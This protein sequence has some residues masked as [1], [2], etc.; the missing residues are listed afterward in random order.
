MS[1]ANNP[2]RE[3]RSLV[4]SRKQQF[5]AFTGMVL[6]LTGLVAT[7]LLGQ[8]NIITIALCLLGIAIGSIMF[9]PR[10]TRNLSVYANM[11]LYALFF[12]AAAIVFFM[13]LQKH[14]LTFDATESRN[15]SLSTVTSNFLERLDQPIRATVFLANKQDRMS[16]SLLLGEYSRYSPNFDYR[17]VDPFRETGLAQRYSA[18]VLP[19][20]VYLERLTTGTEKAERVVKVAKLDEEQLTNGIV[21]LLRGRDITLYFTTGHGEP[22]LEEDKVAA[23]VS[24]QST[25]PNNLQSLTSQLQRAYVRPV[26]I[27]LSRRDSIPVDASAIIVVRP[28]VDF[29]P[30]ETRL[31]RSYLDQGGRVM[32]LLNPDIPQLGTEIRTALIN[33][34]SLIREFGVELPPEVIVMPLAQQSGQSIYMTPVVAKEHRITQD[35]VTREVISV[36]DQSRPVIPGTPPENTFAESFL[37]SGDQAWAFPIEELQKALISRTDPQITA[38]VDDLKPISIGVAATRMAPG[39][40]EEGAAKIM[41]VGNG[42]FVTTRFLA[43]VEWTLF[44]NGVNWLTDSGE[45]IAIPSSEIENTPSILSPG[46]RQ[47]L[48]ILVVIAV[49]TLVALGG[50]GYSISR[51]GTIQ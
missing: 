31:L 40:G 33:L 23:A 26:P 21:Q 16:A 4:I 48:F 38:K 1:T 41:V 46:Q 14:P 28:K 34:G 11:V 32:F 10:V 45:L 36:F 35:V 47:F 2:H 7:A 37:Q 18:Q 29:N 13:I 42:S 24:G 20:D 6:F 30:A 51:R 22:S 50:L 27:D 8:F 19:G 39:K 44:M 49:P 15:Y 5:F 17:I 25:D 12:C 9:L 43:N 3:P